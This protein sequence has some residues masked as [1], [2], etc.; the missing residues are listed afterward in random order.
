[1]EFEEIIKKRRTIRFFKNIPV[2]IQDI[3]T[4]LNAANSS[5][6][7]GNGQ[8]LRYI[9][10]TNEEDRKF[11]LKNTYYAA[12]VAPKR[13]PN[14]EQA[15]QVF[16]LLYCDKNSGD[17]VKCDASAAIMSMQL[18]ATDLTLGACWIGSF[19]E[20]PIKKYLNM[21]DDKKILFLLALGYPDETPA[22]SS[23]KSIDEITKFLD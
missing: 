2:K 12:H 10:I 23:R 11:L 7:A 8:S 9:V 18:A 5:S 16:I 4:I 1:M 3:K 6:S 13:T 20:E 22:P 14:W 21:G 15:P 17:I 19:D